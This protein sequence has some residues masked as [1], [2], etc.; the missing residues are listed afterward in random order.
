MEMTT[1]GKLIPFIMKKVVNKYLAEYY[2]K[3]EINRL[4]KEAGKDYK[5]IIG[6]SPVC[7]GLCDG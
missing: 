7:H 2:S 3:S 5:A 6:R 4:S 1:T